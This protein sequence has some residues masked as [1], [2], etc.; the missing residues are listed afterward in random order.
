MT[1]GVPVSGQLRVFRFGSPRIT[2]TRP[3]LPQN[4]AGAVYTNRGSMF[5]SADAFWRETEQLA[6][7][8]DLKHRPPP[9]LSV[10]FHSVNAEG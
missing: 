3:G 8:Q 2:L 10:Q 6:I 1:A 5:R 4:D 7:G 9:S